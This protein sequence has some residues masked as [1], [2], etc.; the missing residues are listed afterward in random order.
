MSAAEQKL[1]ALAAKNSGVLTYAQ[2]ADFALYDPECG[3]YCKRKTRVGAR[4]DFFTSVSLKEGVFGEAVMCALKKILRGAGIS[5]DASD[6]VEIGAEPEKQ[7]LSGARA[8][9]LGDAIELR[10]CAAVFA[11]EL[12]DARPADRFVFDGKSWRKAAFEFGAAGERREI[13][14]PSTPK[15]GA[16]LDKNFPKARV[17]N[18]KIDI[19]FDA[20]RMFADICAQPWRG[21]IVFADYFR[22]AEEISEMP[23]G[24]LRTYFRHSQSGEIFANLSDADITY[25]PCSDLFAGIARSFGF[26][27]AAQTQESF[28]LEFAG[29]LAQEIISSPDLF[30]PRKRELCQLIN[31]AH[32]GACFRILRC[33]RAQP[34]REVRGLSELGL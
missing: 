11:N 27:A 33:A 16:F 5:P 20:L 22:S 15:E 7:A 10:G 6:F 9:R 29:E 24:T 18:F 32:M 17:K 3:Y 23:A 30:D 2:I 1:A 14:L 12:P 34:P 21:A 13:L 31:P 25:S 28:I 4:G 19:S 8:I 26:S